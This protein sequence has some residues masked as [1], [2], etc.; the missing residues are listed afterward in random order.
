MVKKKQG[1]KRRGVVVSKIKRVKFQKATFKQ[2]YTLETLA[3]PGWRTSMICINQKRR[4]KTKNTWR[5]YMK[6]IT[7]ALDYTSP[8]KIYNLLQKLTSAG[9]AAL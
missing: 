1:K 5:S 8:L 6:K 2:G 7:H 9:N 3:L 4:M